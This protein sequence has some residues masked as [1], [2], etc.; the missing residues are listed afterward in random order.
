MLLWRGDILTRDGGIGKGGGESENQRIGESENQ[1]GAGG[2]DGPVARTETFGLIMRSPAG[3]FQPPKGAL[4]IEPDGHAASGSPRGGL[5]SGGTAGQ[6]GIGGGGPHPTPAALGPKALRA[7][8]C[9]GT[10]SPL[11][12]GGRGEGAGG[13]G[14][15]K[16]PVG[17]WMRSDLP[18]ASAET[19]VMQLVFL[20][21]NCTNLHE[22]KE[23]KFVA[24][25]DSLS[26]NCVNP[27]RNDSTAKRFFIAE[28]AEYAEQY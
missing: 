9:G 20:A 16:C 23:T 15:G 14:E 4:L 24:N 22:L 5:P 25:S 8:A 1:R 2:L 3:C 18:R 13:W 12:P 7:E 11:P 10:P 28:T 27:A 21:T 6:P 26:A 19:G 17:H